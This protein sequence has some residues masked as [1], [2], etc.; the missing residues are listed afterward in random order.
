MPQEA[1]TWLKSHQDH[2]QVGK[3]KVSPTPPERWVNRLGYIPNLNPPKLFW[4]Q[5]LA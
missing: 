4:M 1:V 2:A 5:R 3:K